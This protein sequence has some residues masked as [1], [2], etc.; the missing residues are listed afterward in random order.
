MRY[1]RSVSTANSNPGGPSR[2]SAAV[3]LIARS[4]VLTTMATLIG[5]FLAT[6]VAE[7]RPEPYPVFRSP[8]EPFLALRLF[9]RPETPWG[10]GHRGIDVLADIGQTIMAP[11]DG[12]VSFAGTVVDRGV[13]CLEHKGGW[14]SCFEPVAATVEVGDRVAVGSPVGSLTDEPGHCH[15]DT[16][17]HWGVRFGGDYINPLDVLAGF[18]PV[19]LL[20]LPG[21]GIEP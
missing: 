16:C 12:I 4:I 3:R 20:P 9:D 17:L 15:P 8:V 21:V 19:R 6:S 18:G 1:T 10:P 11:G 5:G 13:V 14:V 2:S 7:A